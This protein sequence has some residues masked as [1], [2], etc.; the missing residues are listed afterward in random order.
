[1]TRE[2]C[3]KLTQLGEAEQA[4]AAPP[5]VRLSTRTD[6]TQASKFPWGLHDGFANRRPDCERLTELSSCGAGGTRTHDPGIMRP[7]APSAVQNPYAIRVWAS[8]PE[9]FRQNPVL[10]ASAPI[11]GV[12][13]PRL[14]G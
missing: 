4:A 9:P 6:G 1:V 12:G 2:A 7:A 14:P 8:S 3:E 10:L 13:P 11:A 5:S